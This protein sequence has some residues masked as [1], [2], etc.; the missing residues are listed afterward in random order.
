MITHTWRYPE[1]VVAFF[2][3]SEPKTDVAS[4]A[5]QGQKWTPWHNKHPTNSIGGE[6]K[7]SSMGRFLPSLLP[8]ETMSRIVM[9]ENDELAGYLWF[10]VVS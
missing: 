2:S 7:L 3:E 10:I 6:T 9:V 8:G 1:I 5:S 4:T